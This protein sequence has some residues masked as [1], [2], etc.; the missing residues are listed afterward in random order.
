[1]KNF[2]HKNVTERQETEK[3]KLLRRKSKSRDLIRIFSREA[4]FIT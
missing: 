3:Q 1:M 4:W 2:T